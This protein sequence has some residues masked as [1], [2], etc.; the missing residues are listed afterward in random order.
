VTLNLERQNHTGGALRVERAIVELRRGR[1]VEIRDARGASIVAAV[2]QLGPEVVE[3]FRAAGPNLDLLLTRERTNVLGLG[4]SPSEVVKLTLPGTIPVAELLA[5]AME[6][7]DQHPPVTGPVK[8]AQ[9]DAREA[10]A[11]ALARNAQLVPALLSRRELQPGS[12]PELLQVGVD[13]IAAYPAMRGRHLRQLSRARVPLA[14]AEDCEFVVFRE[15]FGDADHVAVIIGQP[16]FL[17]PVCVRLHSACLTGDLLASLR[18]DCGDQL[19]GGVTQLREAGGGI[20]LYLAQEGRGIGLVNK[21]RAYTLQ[22]K[23]LDTLQADQHLGFR[24]DER[25]YRVACAML[26]ALSVHRV[27]VLTNNPEKLAGLGACDIEVVERV[28]LPAP[29]NAHNSAYLRTKRE[30]AGHLCTGIQPAGEG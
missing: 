23:G 21:L 18:C 10:A 9:A 14:E 26:E 2:D 3:A 13:D 1:S 4:E 7:G 8:T 30:R 19:R 17:E 12:D 6:L 24:A 15:R 25:D 28:P 27:R 11:V 20:L 16:D 29:V 22:E 5:M